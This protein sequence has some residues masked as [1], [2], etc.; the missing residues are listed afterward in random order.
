MLVEKS[1][2]S[3]EEDISGISII[4]T[5]DD[6]TSEK[7]FPNCGLANAINRRVS[8]MI[9]KKNNILPAFTRCARD[10][11]LAIAVLEKTNAGAFP[12]RPRNKKRRGKSKSSHNM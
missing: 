9:L 11:A 8:A 5:P 3:I 12:L 10:T 4:S 2:A 7:P 6:S 1:N